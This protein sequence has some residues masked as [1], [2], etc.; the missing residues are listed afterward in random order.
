MAGAGQGATSRLLRRSCSLPPAPRACRELAWHAPQPQVRGWGW[1][2]RPGQREPSAGHWARAVGWN[3]QPQIPGAGWVSPRPRLCLRRGRDEWPFQFVLSCVRREPVCWPGP[4]QKEPARDCS[5]G[6]EEG[7]DR[8]APAAGAPAAA[9]C[10]WGGG[11]RRPVLAGGWSK[12]MLAL[13]RLLAGV[14]QTE[15]HT[16]SGQQG[17]PSC[18]CTPLAWAGTWLHTPCMA[19]RP[20]HSCTSCAWPHAW[21][22]TPCTAAQTPYMAACT[23]RAGG[24][25]GH[26]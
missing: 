4:E 14:Q 26:G 23:T 25:M 9:P 6:G 13:P 7:P 11:S 10:R 16:R 18:D 24:A 3:P 15:G 12:D 17:H 22:H 1:R 5:R 21:L 2:G 8:A 20:V 19:A